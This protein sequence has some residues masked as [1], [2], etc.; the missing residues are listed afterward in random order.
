MYGRS[1]VA[2]I[3]GLARRDGRFPLPSQTA[4]LSP[5]MAPYIEP[6]QRA[7]YLKFVAVLVVVAYFVP[8]I[9][10]MVIGFALV[11]LVGGVPAIIGRWLVSKWFE[12][13]RTSAD[14]ADQGDDD[15]V[16]G[17]ELPW[18]ADYRREERIR[19]N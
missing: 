12:L 2:S 10:G 7:G 13:N 19:R 5:I 17:D 15:E 18:Y 4:D 3:L 6:Q 11:L 9:W 8:A 14:V 16:S 1:H